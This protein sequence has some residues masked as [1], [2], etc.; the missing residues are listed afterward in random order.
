MTVKTASPQLARLKAVKFQENN[1]LALTKIGSLSANIGARHKTVIREFG[2]MKVI[3][4]I[5][6]ANHAT[7]KVPNEISI[8]LLAI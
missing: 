6:Y 3:V 5:S 1:L 2:S 8:F 7:L 4:W